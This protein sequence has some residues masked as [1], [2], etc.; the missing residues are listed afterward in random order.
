MKKQLFIIFLV[1]NSI[2][3]FS[4]IG[5]LEPAKDF[6]EYEGILKEYYEN[7]FPLLY[8]G[9][10][11][12]PTARFTSM[13]S[14]S[15]EYSFSVENIA[16]IKYIK[17]NRLSESFW[18]SKKKSKVRVISKKKKISEKLY[19]KITELFKVLENQTKE[20]ED[21]IIGFDGTTYYFATTDNNGE[22]KIGEVWSPKGNSFLAR[23]VATCENIY[24]L[25][26][27]KRI[28]ESKIMESIEILLNELKK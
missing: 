18:Y 8:N 24:S 14:F 20:T 16:G 23:I 22:V 19:L 1:L 15:N 6:R 28:S 3:S 11:E 12:K 25:G 9:F 10:S 4:Q 2:F 17:S 26:K 5:H 27:R 21:G 13:P 7:V